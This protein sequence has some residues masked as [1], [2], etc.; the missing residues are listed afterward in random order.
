[1]NCS[2][3]LGHS[4]YLFQLRFTLP[5]YVLECRSKNTNVSLRSSFILPVTFLDATCSL[6]GKRLDV[7]KTTGTKGS[8]LF[9]SEFCT[10]K[11]YSVSLSCALCC[12]IE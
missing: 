3:Y 12:F 9:P 5:T 8:Q 1:M 2:S 6:Q 10:L 7:E 11:E 4:S